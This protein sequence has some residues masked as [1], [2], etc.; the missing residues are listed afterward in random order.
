MKRLSRMLGVTLLEIMLVLA[1]AA[2]IVVMSIRFYQSATT[3]AYAQDLQNAVA[4]AMSTADSIGLSQ[5]NYQGVTTAVVMSNLPKSITG[6]S[7]DGTINSPWGP[8]KFTITPGGTNNNNYG[9]SVGAGLPSSVCT[10]LAGFI[11]NAAGSHTSG[12]TCA[13]GSVTWTYYLG[14]A[15]GTT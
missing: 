7:T 14:N 9:G 10:Q 6:G 5:G 8:L 11:T 12:A 2:F 13:S 3:S 4:T 1:I 15:P